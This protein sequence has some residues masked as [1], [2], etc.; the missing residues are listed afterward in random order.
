VPRDHREAARW[1][2][3]AAEEGIAG[4]QSALA[5]L[6]WEGSGVPQDKPRA[7]KLWRAAAAKGDTYAKESLAKNGL[8]KK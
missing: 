1:L 3:E 4:A 2:G 7:E 5:A 6:Y 8:N